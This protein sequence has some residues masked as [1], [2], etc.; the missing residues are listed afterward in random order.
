MKLPRP[1]AISRSRNQELCPFLKRIADQMGDSVR[2][3]IERDLKK[4]ERRGIRNR[5]SLKKLLETLP[6]RELSTALW[7]L[8]RAG[9]RSDVSKILVIRR[10]RPKAAVYAI[11]ALAILGG[12]HARRELVRSLND[13]TQPLNVRVAACHGLGHHWRG[14]VRA[15][16]FYPIVSNPGEN[17]SLRGYAIESVGGRIGLRAPGAARSESRKAVDLLFPCLDDQFAEVRFW[18]IF[19]LAGAKAKQAL[20]K[21]RQLA[22]MDH[23]DGPFGWSVAEEAKDA[24]YCQTHNGRWP[25]VDASERRLRAMS[26]TVG[27]ES[28]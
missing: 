1:V 9:K 4:L 5:T 27:K 16:I 22:R 13:Q 26:T 2:E 10:I 14:K 25:K 6:E 23:A 12:K 11:E 3:S 28:S 15:S 8:G 21:L 20:P 19:A 24:V 17:A 18:A 7:V